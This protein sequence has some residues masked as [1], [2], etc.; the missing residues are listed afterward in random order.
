MSK[1]RKVARILLLVG[2]ILCLVFSMLGYFFFGIAFIV[3]P[4]ILT[5]PEVNVIPPEAATYAKI[6]GLAL[7]VIFIFLAI[8]SLVAGI[9]GIQGFKKHEKGNYI[10]NIIFDVLSCI[11]I[12][13]LVGA[14]L[15]LVALRKERKAALAAEPAPEEPAAE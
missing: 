10:A 3:T 13:P 5:M 9:L 4:L 12:I 14:V 7:G 11:Q 8:F 6:G 15:G 2:G 1:L